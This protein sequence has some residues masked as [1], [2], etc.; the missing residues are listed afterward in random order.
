MT[1]QIKTIQTMTAAL[2]LAL[3]AFITGSRAQGPPR[4]TEEQRERLAYFAGKWIL[5]GQS[6]GV[7]VTM[8]ETCEWF[9][10]RFHLVCRREG[11]TADPSLRSRTPDGKLSSQSV[12]GYDAAAKTYTNYVINSSGMGF[13]LRGA[14][15]GKVWTW[16]ADIDANTKLRATM[17]ELAPGSYTAQAEVASIGSNRWAVVEEGTAKKVQ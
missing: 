8:T 12:I 16:N 10:G 14:V 3:G 5:E 1:I 15:D 17:T 11:F 13:L 7:R 9:A 4:M 6:E 2:L